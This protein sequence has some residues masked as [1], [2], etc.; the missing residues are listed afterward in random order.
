M[1]VITFDIA[2]ISTYFKYVSKLLKI[3]K[4]Q[5]FHKQRITALYMSDQG[6]RI[7]VN[8]AEKRGFIRLIVF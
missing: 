5:S 8:E 1:T 4:G 7:L 2:Q 3:K 6:L